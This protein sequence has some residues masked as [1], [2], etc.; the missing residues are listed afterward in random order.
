MADTSPARGQWAVRHVPPPLR[1]IAEL[2]RVGTL[3]AELAS[4]LW[5]LVEGRVPLIVA[6]ADGGSGK[7][8]LLTAL[9]DFLSNNVRM[10]ELAGVD[11]TFDWLPQA[12]ELGWPTKARA[13]DGRDRAR[14]TGN[15]R[16]IRPD[17]TVLL[18]PEL[19]D[20]LP[21]HTWG[22]AARLAVRAASIGYGL[23]ATIRGDG[24][25]D[26]LDAMRR[27]PVGASDDELSR[28][29]VILILRR[30]D[31]DRR[32]VVAAHYLRP[33]AR[34][35]HG[36]VQRLGPAVLT[37]WDGTRDVFEHFGW[38]INPELAMRVGRRAGD[39]EL[40]VDSR[41]TFLDGLLE[42]G[43]IEV[44]GV[45]AAIA[46]YRDLPASPTQLPASPTH[47]SAPRTN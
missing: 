25:N 21:S 10:I 9:L 31:A 45:R 19:S 47:P 18:V 40:E 38:G 24:L 27:P 11:E 37:A 3:D 30:I 39:F 43:T 15:G 23:A 2:I 41:R 13:N 36:H 1:S 14:K 4:I 12:G 17:D 7:T 28:L 32:R 29:G 46:G 8:T 34:D 33:T 20:R 6:A 35:E 44:E 16:P 22:E 42:S 5:I 26:V